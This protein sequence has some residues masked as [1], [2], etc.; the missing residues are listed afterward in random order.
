M[1][2]MITARKAV[3]ELQLVYGI[4]VDRV[5]TGTLMTSLDMVEETV[6]QRKF[7]VPLPPSP[8]IKD[9]EIFAPSQE[10]SKQGC[11]LEAAIEASATAIIN[12]KDS[13]NE[14]DS[15]VGDGDCGTTMC[16]GAIA[17]LEDMKKRLE[18]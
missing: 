15:K 11:I 5:Y 10:L 13:L 16:R 14:W 4:V 9:D 1:E 6:H 8:S 7:P 17:I 18:I 3:P 2:L 12:L